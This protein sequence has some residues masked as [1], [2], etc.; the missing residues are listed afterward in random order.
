MENKVT[1]YSVSK[2]LHDLNFQ[3]E[4]HCGW[5]ARIGF[6][7]LDN[8]PSYGWSAHRIWIDEFLYPNPIERINAYDCHDCI[9]YLMNKGY[10][11]FKLCGLPDKCVNE[12]A[13]IIIGDLE[14]NEQ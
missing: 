3:C 11:T 1:N 10:D 8:K 9:V 13:G 5:W 7:L 12:L 2:R 4:S 6:N 14:K